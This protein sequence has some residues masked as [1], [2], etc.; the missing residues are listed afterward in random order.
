MSQHTNHDGWRARSP[1]DRG[2]SVRGPSVRDLCA[3]GICALGLWSCRTPEPE[4][5]SPTDPG[6]REDP[7]LGL[8]I[9][10]GS[11]LEGLPE[12]ERGLDGGGRR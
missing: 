6:V 4:P 10:S 8:R 1:A 5:E 9:H 12:P 7:D 2:P 11:V 3:L